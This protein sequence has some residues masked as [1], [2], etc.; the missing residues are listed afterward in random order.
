MLSLDSLGINKED[1]FRVS[2]TP[3]HVIN[4]QM[5]IWRN[6]AS[7]EIFPN[8]KGVYCYEIIAERNSICDNCAVVETLRDGIAQ[9][10]ERRFKK[11]IF[12]V[13]I[14]PF[15]NEKR[16]IMGVTETLEDITDSVVRQQKLEE[17]A[18]TDELTG[19]YNRRGII[20]IAK[21]EVSRSVRHE[22]QLCAILLDIDNFKLINDTYGHS[23]GD[24][25]LID[26]SSH[27]KKIIRTIDKVGRYG[28]DEFLI[29]LPE[30]SFK[31]V[32]D[33]IS[34]IR[35][36]INN[37]EFLAENGDL[38]KV[39]VSMGASAYVAGDIDD[40]IKEADDLMYK[41]KSKKQN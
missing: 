25:V 5:I 36:E 27:I 33:L 19:I 11:K 17:M 15:F 10:K 16:L 23:I 1:I 30:T 39:L 18:V 4:K 24:N 14:N 41:E 38:I 6:R 3:I 26:F 35:G 29:I 8:E 34:R 2:G 9:I 28:G 13:R 32:D 7:K 21:D 37:F 40:M 31:E 22:S 12:K 20:N